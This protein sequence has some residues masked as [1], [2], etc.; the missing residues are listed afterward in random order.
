MKFI[1][2]INRN[3]LPL[4]ASSINDA[5]AQDNQIRLINLFVESLK[6]TDFGFT[7]DFV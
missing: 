7:F 1:N 6:L 2:G 5:I 3:Q 4:F